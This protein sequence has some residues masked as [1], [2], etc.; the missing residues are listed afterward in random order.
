L[1]GCGSQFFSIGPIGLIVGRGDQLKT[2]SRACDLP[3]DQT[4]VSLRLNASNLL[5][6]S[7]RVLA[8]MLSRRCARNKI[9]G[10]RVVRRRR[11]YIGYADR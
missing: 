10:L 5:A 2:I 6:V 7:F 8:A 4:V 1:N 3:D 9:S 11:R